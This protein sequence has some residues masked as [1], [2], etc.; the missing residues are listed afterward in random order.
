[1][2]PNRGGHHAPFLNENGQHE[3]SIVGGERN[4]RCRGECLGELRE[5]AGLNAFP[6]D[7]WALIGIVCPTQS[8]EVTDHRVK[9]SEHR[10]N[11]IACKKGYC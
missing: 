11:T 3:G 1:M 4:E 7:G 10:F 6:F 9:C 8:E 2:A 5:R